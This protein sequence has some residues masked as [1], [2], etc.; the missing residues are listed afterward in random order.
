MLCLFCDS[1]ESYLWLLQSTFLHRQWLFFITWYVH[2][3]V[4]IIPSCVCI[5]PWRWWNNLGQAWLE[6]SLGI[7]NVLNG[8]TSQ[9]SMVI[10]LQEMVSYSSRD[11]LLVVISQNRKNSTQKFHF[12]SQAELTVSMFHTPLPFMWVLML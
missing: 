3:G 12:R 9:S 4:W 7:M 6:Q 2:S 1:N 11:M 5:S 10:T 8:F